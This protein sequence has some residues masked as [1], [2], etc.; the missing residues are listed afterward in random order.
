MTIYNYWDIPEEQYYKWHE[1]Y[2]NQK[3]KKKDE[4]RASGTRGRASTSP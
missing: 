3:E 4:R 1:W 2:I